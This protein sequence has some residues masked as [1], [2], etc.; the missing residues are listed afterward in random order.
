M[1]TSALEERVQTDQPFSG[2]IQS[3]MHLFVHILMEHRMICADSGFRLW[4]LIPTAASWSEP[5]GGTHG[6]NL[7]EPPENTKLQPICSRRSQTMWTTSP[8]ALGRK[9]SSLEEPDTLLNSLDNLF[10]LQSPSFSSLQA[11]LFSTTPGLQQKAYYCNWQCIDTYSTICKHQNKFTL[12]HI[13]I[14][15]M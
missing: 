15:I 10:N 8:T 4:E 14:E 5:E 6:F 7:P 2:Y 1:W 11:Y 3:N 9:G 12:Q 13:P